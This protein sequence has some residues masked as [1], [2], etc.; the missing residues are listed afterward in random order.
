MA[1]M[2]PEGV[3]AIARVAPIHLETRTVYVEA[4]VARQLGLHDGQIVQAVAAMRNDQLKLVLNE[5]SFNIPLFPY[6]KEGD[7]LQ[8]RAQELSNGKWALQ[9]LHTGSFAGTEASQAAI[10]TR[11]NALMFQP[12]GFANLLTLLRPGVLESLVPP[13]Q[14]AAELKKRINAQ[15][16]SMGGLQAQ[17]LKR[18]VLGHAKTSESSLADGDAVPDNTK[19]LLRLLMAEREGIEDKDA[20]SEH[21][22]HH[23]LDE[24]EA[25]QVQS[26]QN[27]HK[28]DLNLAL[29]IPFR[30]ADPVEL[31][32]EQKGNKPGQPKNP[33]VVNMHTQSRVLGEVWLKTTISNSSQV[34][35]TMWAVKKDIAELAKFN[36]SELTYELENAGLVMGSFQVF[37]APRP[38]AKQDRPTPDHG[39]LVDTQA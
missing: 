38:D 9:L 5:H 27:L 23:A 34:D 17:T 25:A 32:F 2:G 7:H 12:G 39:A 10:P 14:D 35:L 37:N 33:L 31:H 26:A 16:L 19:V 11:L 36:A 13:V 1:I 22:L 3:H 18:F 15:R 6:I 4:P 20:D 21:S 28:G 8:L 24:L 29:V 30:D